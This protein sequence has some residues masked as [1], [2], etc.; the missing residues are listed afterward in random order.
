MAEQIQMKPSDMKKG[1]RKALATKKTLDEQVIKSMDAL[2]NELQSQWKGD[3]MEGYK[4]RYKKIRSALNNAG[5]LL[6]EI[7]DNLNTTA[8]IME[9]TDTRISNQ[10]RRNG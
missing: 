4:A 6:K 10:Y 9:E 8:Q 7:H 1:A 3:S 2:L 5:D